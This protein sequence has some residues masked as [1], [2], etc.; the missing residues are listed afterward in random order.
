MFPVEF[1]LSTYYTNKMTDGQMV[2]PDGFC[3][4][5]GRTFEWTRLHKEQWVEFTIDKMTNPSGTF[6]LWQDYLL[7]YYAQ[8]SKIKLRPATSEDRTAD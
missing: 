7:N 2:W 6:K 5:G 3:G 4:I 8:E 1:N